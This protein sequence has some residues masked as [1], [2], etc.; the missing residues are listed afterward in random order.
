M[1]AQQ[2]PALNTDLARLRSRSK[3]NFGQMAEAI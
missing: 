1:L 3:E 2:K